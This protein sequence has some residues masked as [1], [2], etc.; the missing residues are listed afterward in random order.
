MEEPQAAPLCG[1]QSEVSLRS[2]HKGGEGEGGVCRGGGGDGVV[3]VGDILYIWRIFF[4]YSCSS[5]FR[6]GSVDC[7]CTQ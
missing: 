2:E 5:E 6:A 3:W 4:V 1:E 7:I